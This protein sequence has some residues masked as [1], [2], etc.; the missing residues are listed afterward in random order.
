MKRLLLLVGLCF[1]LPSGYAEDKPPA[2]VAME[3]ARAALHTGHVVWSTRCNLPRKDDGIIYRWYSYDVPRYY[4]SRFTS[5][6]YMVED[7]GDPRGVVWPMRDGKPHPDMGYLPM[8]YLWY[9]GAQWNHRDRVPAAELYPGYRDAVDVRTFGLAVALATC[10]WQTLL[11]GSKRGPYEVR[12]VDGLHEVSL[13]AEKVDRTVRYLVDPERGWNPVR[14]TKLSGGKVLWESRTTLKE[15]G[16]VWFPEQVELFESTHEEGK[17]PVYVIDIL[18]ASFNQPDHPT[19]LTPESIG[20]EVGTQIQAYAEGNVT[21][22]SG[23]FGWDKKKLVPL[24]E[25]F[26]RIRSGELETGPQTKAYIDRSLALGRRSDHFQSEWERYVRR[27]IKKYRLNDEQ[28]EK[29]LKILRSCQERGEEYISRHKDEM[30]EI[31]ATVRGLTDP[32]KPQEVKRSKEIPKLKERMIALQ[33][34]LTDIFYRQL[35]PRLEK[36]PTRAQRKAVAER[37]QSGKKG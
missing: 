14:V 1:A 26:Q 30:D 24:K 2:L 16:G 23:R 34:P 11:R 21:R 4:T 8:R 27:F 12:I 33:A 28:S 17:Q 18:S 37:E 36:L 31:R 32:T 22:P 6:E 15:Y 7:N 35:M 29:A 19:R 9:D 5:G 10:D 25:L 3:N 20:I 13:H